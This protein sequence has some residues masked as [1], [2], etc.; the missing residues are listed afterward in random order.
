MMQLSRAS[1]P[2][3]SVAAAAATRAMSSIGNIAA[4]A[5]ASSTEQAP[6]AA[7]P[8]AEAAPV[9]DA[10]PERP[11]VIKA[12]VGGSYASVRAPA[13]RSF[14]QRPK[15]GESILDIVAGNSINK[16]FKNGDMYTLKDL[17]ETSGAPRV[18]FG[19]LTHY[20]FDAFKAMGTNPLALYKDAGVLGNFVT[21][22]GMIMHRK[23]TNL[24]AKHQRKLTKAIKRARAMGLMPYTYRPELKR[25]S[26][27]EFMNMEVNK[28]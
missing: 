15:A 1:A 2:I 22:T 20:K 8:A 23:N 7:A 6:E 17:D 12:A 10:A 13:R 24:T 16:N 25:T 27:K 21:E 5:I 9:A 14:G 18:A 11:S 19:S 4:A 3:S 28:R 26:A